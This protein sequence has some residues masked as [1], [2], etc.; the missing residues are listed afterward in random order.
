MVLSMQSLIGATIALGD[1]A[2]I[3]DAQNVRRILLVV[4]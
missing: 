2:K 1:A 4:A 3:D